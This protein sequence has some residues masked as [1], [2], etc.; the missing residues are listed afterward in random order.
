MKAWRLDRLG[1][2]LNFKDIAVPEVRPGSVLVRIE[3]SALMSYLKAYVEGKLPAY[4]PPKGAFTPGSNGVGVVHAIGRDV[5][6]LKPGERVV[7]SPH[8]VAPEN[9]EEP[10]QI[11]IGLTAFGPGAEA[12]QADWRDGTLAEYALMHPTTV[13][14]AE[15][16][17]HIDSAQLVVVTRYIV[18]FGGLL[19]GRLA[20][21]ETLIVTGATGAYGTAAVLLGIAMGAGRVVAAGRNREALEAVARAGGARVVPVVLTGDIQKD[22]SALRA[23]ANGGAQMTFDMVGQ[24]RDPNATL[25][26][27]RSLRRGGRLVLMGSMSAPL[28][29]SYMELMANNWEIMG[30]FMYPADAYRRLLDLVRAGLLDISAIRPRVFPLSALPEAMKAAAAAGSLECVVVQP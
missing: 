20:A 19:R 30:Q 1:G 5:W 17:S 28:P 29:L 14:P 13:T 23:A 24:A 3:A 27:L 6:H 16:L 18:P 2:G 21:G 8:L 10:A 7:L 9:V 26:A 15:G 22:V 25:A 4:N 11:L 12:V